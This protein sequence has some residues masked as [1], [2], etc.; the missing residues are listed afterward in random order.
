MKAFEIAHKMLKKWGKNTV[1][2]LG[3]MPKNL[4][5]RQGIWGKINLYWQID[6]TFRDNKNTSM[7]KTGAKKPQTMKKI[8]LS[9]LRL[10]KEDYQPGMRD[11]I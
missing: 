4:S 1:I 5:G 6:F 9:I 8:A 3:K 7:V 2:V 11:P 10:M